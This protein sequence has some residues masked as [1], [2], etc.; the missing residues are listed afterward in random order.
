MK[1][2]IQF[3]RIIRFCQKHFIHNYRIN[4][5]MSIDVY[6]NV[7]IA[8]NSYKEIPIKFNKVFGNFNCSHNKLTTLINL[9]KEIHGDLDISNNNIKDLAFI[10]QSGIVNLYAED[11]HNLKD[12]SNLPLTIIETV[13]LDTSNLDSDHKNKINLNKNYKKVFNLN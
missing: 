12:I 6:H 2:L 4:K 8:V 10:T 3:F 1:R 13:F 7:D 11:L 5:D 9:P